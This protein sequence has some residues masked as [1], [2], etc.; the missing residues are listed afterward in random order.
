[1]NATKNLYEETRGLQY[2]HII[3]SFKPDETN[4]EKA[5]ELGLELALSFPLVKF[6]L[7]GLRFMISESINPQLGIRDIIVLFLNTVIFYWTT[8]INFG[9]LP[10]LKLPEVYLFSSIAFFGEYYV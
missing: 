2:H 9:L 10:A 3:Q 4:P 7:P 8:L 6:K 5:H 1:M